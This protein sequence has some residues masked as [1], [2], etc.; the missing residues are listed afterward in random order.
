LDD[1]LQELIGK[2]GEI[3]L[4]VVFGGNALGGRVSY[5]AEGTLVRKNP[6]NAVDE[7]HQRARLVEDGENRQSEWMPGSA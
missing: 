7:I 5:F 6:L 1:A 4:A 3:T 2:L